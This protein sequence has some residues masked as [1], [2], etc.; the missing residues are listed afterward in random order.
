MNKICRKCDIEKPLEQFRKNNK[1]KDRLF[2]YCIECQ[3]IINKKLYIK[4]KQKRLAQITKW[5]L[6]HPDKLKTYKSNWRE[7]K[8]KQITS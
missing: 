2:P 3:N 7:N 6:E 8:N 4:N 5:N 1:T